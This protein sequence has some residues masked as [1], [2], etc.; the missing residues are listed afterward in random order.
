MGKVCY[1]VE[2]VMLCE[3][4]FVLVFSYD[5]EMLFIDVVYWVCYKGLLVDEVIMLLLGCCIKFE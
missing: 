3:F 5:V 1:V 2:G 4:V